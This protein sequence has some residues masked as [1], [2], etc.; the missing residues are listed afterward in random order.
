M[1]AIRTGAVVISISLLLG[2]LGSVSQHRVEAA[3][4][5]SLTIGAGALPDTLDP[6]LSLAGLAV[7]VYGNVFDALTAIDFSK[8]TAEVAPLLASSWRLVNPT[9]WEFKL[10]SGVQ[11]SN[12][13]PFTAEAVKFNIDRILDPATKSPARGRIATVESAQVVDATTV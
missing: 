2:L 7:V 6:H 3:P 1:H 8:S 4:T 10:K 11:F 5:G 12:G 9:T 13:E